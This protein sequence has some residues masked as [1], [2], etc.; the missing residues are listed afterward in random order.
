MSKKYAINEIFYSL[1]GEGMRAGTANIFIRFAGCNLACEMKPGPKSPGGFD[2]DTEFS[3][4]R[5][6]ELPEIAEWIASAACIGLG[7]PFV[8]RNTWRHLTDLPFWIDYQPWIIVTGGEPALQ[9]DSEFCEY[10]HDE[11]FYI[12]IE[13]N[14]TIKLPSHLD[15]GIDPGSVDWITMSPKTAE[16]TLKQPYADELKYV[17]A[18]GQDIPK[19][20]VTAKHYLISPAFDNGVVHPETMKWCIDLCL[21]N[22]QW[23]LSLQ[24][25]KFMNVR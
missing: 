5:K 7:V 10:F 1:Q 23:R 19:P 22:P 3:S 25:H 15:N 18:Y 24:T 2:C 16:H 6:L 4:G 21:K 17:R 8:N 9:L 13:T 12:A 11:G 20:S 14:G